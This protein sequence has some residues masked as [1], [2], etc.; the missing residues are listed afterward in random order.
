MSDNLPSFPQGFLAKCPHCKISQAEAIIVFFFRTSFNSVSVRIH[1]VLTDIVVA[2]FQTYSGRG[3]SN[4][5]SSTTWMFRTVF[6]VGITFSIR[7]ELPFLPVT[8]TT[9]T[10]SVLLICKERISIP[11]T[12]SSSTRASVSTTSGSTR[13]S[14]TTNSSSTATVSTHSSHEF[15]DGVETGVDSVKGFSTES[16]RRIESE[17]TSPDIGEASTDCFTSAK[18][19]IEQALVDMADSSNSSTCNLD[20][21][22][23][24]DTLGDGST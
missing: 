9:T 14:S 19:S 2:C 6:F 23:T 11:V 21:C 17:K 5:C 1:P 7:N 4:Q 15:D 20:A 12:G 10:S 13:G 18:Q 16:A 3:I 22:L 8:S 24:K